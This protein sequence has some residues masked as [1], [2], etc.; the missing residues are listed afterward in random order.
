MTY[1]KSI[2]NWPEPGG[3]RWDISENY[4]LLTNK[5]NFPGNYKNNKNHTNRLKIVLLVL[6]HQF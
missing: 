1:A 5:G 3:Q 6:E 4:S 2:S